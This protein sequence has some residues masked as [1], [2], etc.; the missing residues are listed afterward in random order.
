[1]HLLEKDN[2]QGRGGK[3]TVKGIRLE[4]GWLQIGNRIL[5]FT[6]D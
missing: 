6:S 2:R 3:M 1:M 4:E 5:Y